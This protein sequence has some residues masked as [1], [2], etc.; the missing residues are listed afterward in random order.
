MKFSREWLSDYVELP[1]A[2]DELAARLTAAGLAVEGVEVLGGDRVLEVDV[3]TNRPD[4][5][6]HLGLARELA[7]L[8]GRPLSS[9]LS[10]P[11]AAEPGS[12]PVELADA[13][14]R[15]YVARVV[16]GVKV[17][18]SPD[19]LRRRLVGLGLRPINN[20][21]DVTN[22]VLWE[23]GQPIHAFDLAKLAGGRVV[24]RAAL[25][26]EL[27]VTLD[28]EKRGLDGEVLVIADAE[29]AVALAGIMG[30]LASEVT[31]STADVLIE[32]A[33][34]DPTR[35]RRGAARLGMHTDASHRFER[36]ADPGA[37]RAAADRV[38]ALLAEIAGGEVEP[39]ATDVFDDPG[40]SG[41]VGTLDGKRLARFAGF[42]VPAEEIERSL[43]GL[44]F[45]PR[46][47]GDGVWRVTVP[48]WR[49]YDFRD[50]KESGEVW[51]ADLYEEVLRIAGF[52]RLPSALPAI[53]GPDEG[54]SAGHELRRRI[55]TRL[56]ASGYREAINYSFHSREAGAALVGLGRPEE[57]LVL[58]NP[59][60]EQL[61]VMRRS[62][63]PGLVESARFNLR[64]GATEVMLFEIGHLFPGGDADEVETVALVGGGAPGTPWDGRRELDL[65]DLRGAVDALAEAF[66]VRLEARRAELPGMIPGSSSELLADGRRRGW[67]GRLDDPDL[68]FPLYLAELETA[69]LGTAPAAPALRL[70]SRFPG[71]ATDLT[72]THPAAV[73]WREIVEA[74][75]AARPSELVEWGLKDRYAGEGVPEGAVNT[76]IYFL[77]NA[78]DRS[79]TREEVHESHEALADLLR[80]RFGEAERKA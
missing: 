72:L 71:V 40:F 15:R 46:P 69:V 13:D 38:A 20:V 17:G 43:A 28:G 30:G 49:Y 76:T 32:S 1:D 80:R 26:G 42:E 68:P 45:A 79:L 54:S 53:A 18:P 23:T 75:E 22:F 3:T 4:C 61:A 70:P 9:P 58:A 73:S 12:V 78:E 35:V 27:L 52:E 10:E 36:G 31:E 24:V 50:R 6:C 60:S 34:F 64:R 65:F 47:E 74:V 37:C 33:H 39:G 21:V 7:T 16:R 55:R 51:E 8:F 2:A 29:R 66:A 62:L 5:M 77:Y 25:A 56:A 44:G 63:L 41:L 14:C 67:M 48:T 19:W 59:L 11:A 57:A